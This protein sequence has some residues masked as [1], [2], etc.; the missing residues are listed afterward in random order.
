MAFMVRY[1]SRFK[2]FTQPQRLRSIMRLFLNALTGL[3]TLLLVV[4]LVP[5][6]LDAAPGKQRLADQSKTKASVAA[7]SS[8]KTQ[9]AVKKKAKATAQNVRTTKP[10]VKAQSKVATSAARKAKPVAKA[11]T[12]KKQQAVAAASQKSRSKQTV[13]SQVQP[14]SSQS[15]QT[16]AARSKALRNQPAT[17]ARIHTRS[18][19]SIPSAA[20]FSS[21]AT[22]PL[23]TDNI[24]NPIEAPLKLTSRSYM[25]MDAVSGGTIL[26][27]NPDTPRQPASTIKILTGLIA[28]K[29]LGDNDSVSVSRHAASMPSSKVH[30]QTKKNYRANDLINSVLLASAND[31]SVAL[32]ERIAGSESRFAQLMTYSA[33]RWGAQNTVCR[34]ASGLTAEGQQSTARDLAQLFRVAMQDKEFAKRMRERSAT[35]AFGKTLRNHN[36]ALWQ[37]D[38]AMAG[39]TGYTNAARQTYVGQFNRDGHTIVV[40]IM[41]DNPEVMG[42]INSLSGQVEN[43]F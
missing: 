35:T 39:K 23:P 34:T 20:A 15:R 6:S 26:A 5:S 32:A 11:K 29:S 36:K 33:Q 14:P 2:V 28:L 17:S 25:V 10:V 3:F 40:A 41:G 19:Q 42:I 38:G 31:A 21:S 4:S 9:P 12:T 7:Q 43:L 18:L 22:L 27:K 13:R 8:R 1:L 16:L 30:L 24:F 37:L